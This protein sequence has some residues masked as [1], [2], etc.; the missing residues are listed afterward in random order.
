MG[1]LYQS[2]IIAHQEEFGHSQTV[3]LMMPSTG[4]GRTK[5]FVDGEVSLKFKIGGAPITMKIKY[6]H[7][8]SNNVVVYQDVLYSDDALKKKIEE[9]PAMMAKIDS[10]LR[11]RLAERNHSAPA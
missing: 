8:P 5:R 2:D 3:T 10:Y 1:F 6:R 4:A 7:F 9:Q 11:G